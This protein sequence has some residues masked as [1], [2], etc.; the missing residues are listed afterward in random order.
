MMCSTS[1]NL[2]RFFGRLAGTF[3]VPGEFVEPFLFGSFPLTKRRASDPNVPERSEGRSEHEAG[4][5][6]L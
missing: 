2:P 6:G 5:V 1:L 3:N 4:R